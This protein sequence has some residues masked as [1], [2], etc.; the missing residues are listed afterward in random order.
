MEPRLDSW[1]HNQSWDAEICF[2]WLSF[3]RPEAELPHMEAVIG[4]VDEVSSVELPR[5]LDG[6][7]ETCRI[8]K[9][10][11]GVMDS[12]GW[13]V[14]SCQDLRRYRPPT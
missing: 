9:N 1:A 12:G 11:L 7:V 8:N 10:A 5:F 3:A 13:R 14:Q 6:I 2:V 4:R